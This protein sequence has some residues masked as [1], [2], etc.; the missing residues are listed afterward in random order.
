MSAQSPGR[1]GKALQRFTVEPFWDMSPSSRDDLSRRAGLLRRFR[2]VTPYRRFIFLLAVILVASTLVLWS[3]VIHLLD[4]YVYTETA[5]ITH[6]GVQVQFATDFPP[7]I[8]ERPLT[9]E[10][11]DRVYQVIRQHFGV[12]NIVEARFYRPDGTVTFSYMRNQIG[13]PQL[14]GDSHDELEEALAGE[15]VMQ[16]RSLPASDNITRTNLPDVLETY[17]PIWSNGHVIGVAEVYRD[18][19]DLVAT[20]RTMQT[21]ILAVMASISAVLFLGLTRIYSQ[22]TKTILRQEQELREALSRLQQSYD[23]TLQALV[24]ALDARDHETEGHSQRVT[25]YALAIGRELGFDAAALAKL[26]QGAMLHDIGKIGVPDGILRK[27]GPLNDEEW[28][29]MRRHPEI[30]ARM[31]EN[32]PFLRPALD[33]VA[34]HHERWDGRGYPSGLRE[35]G[36]PLTARAFA[37]A[38]AFDAMTSD[39]PYHRARSCAAAR[40]EIQRSG[41]SQ[42]DTDVVTAFLRISDQDLAVIRETG[43]LAA[44]AQEAVA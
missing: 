25:A 36:I 31:L 32:I 26:E 41:G 1:F 17:V 16:V 37:V 12:Y 35:E 20:K 39:R 19:T 18:L 29:A 34:H 8:F 4:D 6:D 43:R 7:D 28:A 40:L 5:R 38:D 14:T 22:S 21:T 42:F 2:S 24:A 44:D 13:A 10:E 27:A 15:P 9:G 33:V 23:G 11:Y 3:V 30:G